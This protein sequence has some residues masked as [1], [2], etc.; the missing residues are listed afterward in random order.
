MEPPIMNP[1]AKFIIIG[2]IIMILVGL[3]VQFGWKFVPLGK[4]PGDIVVEKQNF[5]FYFPVVTS[6]IVSVVLT[7]IF[8]LIR[9]FGK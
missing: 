2:G 4:M 9:M 6:I 1:I 3:F 8:W 7:L 5:S